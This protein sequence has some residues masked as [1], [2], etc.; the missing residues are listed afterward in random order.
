MRILHIDKF[1]PGWGYGGGVESCIDAMTAAQRARG[2]NVME[3]GT[4]RGD[5]APEMPRFFDF[6]ASRSPWNLPRMIHNGAAAGKLEK[7]LQ[8][9]KVDIAHVHSIYH[10]LTPSILPVLARRRIGIVMQMHDYRLACPAKHFL[11][12]RDGVHCMR[13]H[14]NKY[15]HAAGG[16]CAGLAGAGSAVES[17]ISRLTRSYFRLVDFFVCPT[18][19]MRGIMRR[20][21]APRSKL[22][23]LRNMVSA[24]AR[25]LR[26]AEIPRRVLF[27]GRMSPEKAPEMMLDLAERVEKIEVI[28]AGDG[29]MLDELRRSAAGRGLDNV[30]FTGHVS[31]DE[32]GALIYS[33]SAVIVTSRW[34]ENSTMTMLE[35]M[36]AG[37]CVIVPD[38]GP[39]REWIEDGQTGRLFAPDDIDSLVTVTQEVLSNAAKRHRMARAGKKL[40]TARHEP[41]LIAD[42]LEILYREASARCALR[43]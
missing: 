17:Y 30:T 5:D 26:Q 35:A 10:H 40:A 27:A 22:I 1:L 29:P 23:V 33:S 32:V 36:L 31:C 19:F 9:C 2:H 37:R 28:L 15:F 43:W 34:L 21:G 7:L 11:R 6:A 18:R 20:I 13:C 16:G 41:D 25:N 3:F 12:P 14:P 39:L 8:S 42:R 4:A 38:R 24:P